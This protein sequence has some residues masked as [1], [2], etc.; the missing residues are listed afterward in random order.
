MGTTEIA[1][2]SVQRHNHTRSSTTRIPWITLTSLYT[3]LPHKIPFKF[4]D[5]FCTQHRTTHDDFCVFT[6]LHFLVRRG[7]A[8]GQVVP[9]PHINRVS[10]FGYN[11]A[12]SQPRRLVSAHKPSGSYLSLLT[13]SAYFIANIH[14]AVPSRFLSYSSSLLAS[15]P[16]THVQY[17][18]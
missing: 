8:G 17:F 2:C 1:I 12:H 16:H 7:E 5:Y 9:L 4:L 11:F 3:V 6:A 14:D 15:S 18:M 13:S 10:L